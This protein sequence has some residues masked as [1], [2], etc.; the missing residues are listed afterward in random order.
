[1]FLVALCVELLFGDRLQKSDVS[2]TIFSAFIRPL[3]N[4]Y[5]GVSGPVKASKGTALPFTFTYDCLLMVATGVTV[6]PHSHFSYCPGWSSFKRF[7]HPKLHRFSAVHSGW[8]R[9]VVALGHLRCL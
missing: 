5:D 4:N 6:A 1:M 2:E 7:L 9:K 3:Y 8:W